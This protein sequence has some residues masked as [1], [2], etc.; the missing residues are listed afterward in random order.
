MRTIKVCMENGDYFYTRIN[1]TP[2]EIARLYLGR[3]HVYERYD[4]TEEKTRFC[5]VEYLDD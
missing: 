4:G 2:D 5:R 1:A 3:P